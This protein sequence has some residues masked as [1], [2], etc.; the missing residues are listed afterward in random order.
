MST[1][2]QVLGDGHLDEKPTLAALL[3][4][5]VTEFGEDR[6]RWVLERELHP[7]P[8]P[9]QMEAAREEHCNDEV[10]IDDDA[11]LSETDEGYW[12]SAWV[13]MGFPECGRCRDVHDPKLGCDEP[14]PEPDDVTGREVL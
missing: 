14:E 13:W 1:V 8:T 11:F 3:T 6:M 9:D 12:V 7:K 4:R 10:N 2:M 5:L